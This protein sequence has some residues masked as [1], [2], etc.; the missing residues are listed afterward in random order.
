[1]KKVLSII[2]CAAL[3]LAVFAGC[4]VKKTS[5]E[6][7]HI[8]A[9][10]YPEYEWI[11]QITEGADNVEVSLLLDSGADLHNFQPSVKDITDISSSD[12]FVYN[13]GESDEW[14]DNIKENAQNKD[15]LALDLM[16]LLGDK[17]KEETAVEGM[18]T[19]EHEEEEDEKEY[20]EHIWLSLKNASFLCQ[21]I[22]DRLSEKDPDN[23][24]TYAKNAKAYIEKLNKLDAE[25]EQTCSS[26]KNDTLI[27]A[28]R[29]PFRYMTDDYKLNYYAAFSGCSA[30]SD[31]KFETI[32]FLANK[33]DELK[34]DHLMIIDG[35]DDKLAKSVIDA[36]KTK[37]VK[38]L[39][40]NSMQ[41]SVG[42]N[43]TYLGIME[44][45][46]K[47]LKEALN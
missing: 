25:Y 1:M 7:L 13:G 22:A 26:A 34:L 35:S 11:K 23:K 33:L 12:V 32:V 21:K 17:A 2:I 3:M 30:Q 8:I 46:L 45:N 27:F 14:V 4:G 29:F 16:E 20:D 39:T 28:D 15:M 36:A 40:L 43:S 9:T 18:E 6:K 47:A 24:D 44:D 38:I 5:G 42:E 31:P 37:D 41:S 10:I 19:E